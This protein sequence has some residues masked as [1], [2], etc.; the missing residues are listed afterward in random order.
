MLVI[1]WCY[2]YRCGKLLLT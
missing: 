2:F 1:F